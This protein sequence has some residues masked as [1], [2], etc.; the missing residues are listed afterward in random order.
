[1]NVFKKWS[2]RPS[3]TLLLLLIGVI[4]AA[5][6][7]LV[8]A[9]HQV[10]NNLPMPPPLLATLLIPVLFALTLLALHLMMLWRGIAMEQVILP[11]AALLM[12]L[13]L[14]MIWRL[15]GSEGVWQQMTRGFFPG[16]LLIGALVLRPRWVERIRQAAIPIS[17]IGLAL[18]V[19]TAFIGVQDET[20]ARLSIKLGPLPAI[21]TSELLKLALIIFLAWYIEREGEAAEG[22]AVILFGF[23]RLPPLRY[24]LP[25][26]LFAGLTILALV[27]MSDFGAVIIMAILFISMLY[28][29]FQTRTFLTIAL[30]GVAFALLAG[31]ILYAFWHVP[32]VIRYR[33]EAFLNPWST[34]PL[35]VNGKPNGLTIAEGPG[36]Q[37]QQSIYA[38]LAGGVTGTGLGFGYP[39]FI[40]LAHSDFI[41][42]AILEE[43]GSATGLA[44]LAVYAVLIIRML[45]VAALLPRT[46]IFERL[47]LTGIAM[48]FFSQTLIMV[49]GTVDM[50]PMTGV[51]LPFLSLGGMALLVNLFEIGL[52][53][54]IMQHMNQVAR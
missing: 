49:G 39:Q 42:A 7:F 6:F 34:A 47:L 16:V 54:A 10:Q 14:T 38:L 43:M 52:A 50:L 29:G 28:A 31:L 40:P 44:I 51:T 17:L 33:F 22:R 25:G 45:R 19:I 36:Y 23:L 35:L 53:L 15:R 3:E 20:G 8:D 48:H 4:C 27:K 9:A 37:I 21:Q 46:Q 12:A 2:S 30:I 41:F 32:D 24:F 13:G 1:M 26:A 11:C 5:G 18:T